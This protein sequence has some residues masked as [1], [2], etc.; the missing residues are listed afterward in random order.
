MKTIQHTLSLKCSYP[1]ERLLSSLPP[2]PT[3]TSGPIGNP[4]F[5]DIETTG[6]SGDRSMLYLIG[7]LVPG[8][9]GFRAGAADRLFHPSK[10]AGPPEG[11]SHPAPF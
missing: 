10:G 2:D 9:T 4:L 6:F 8:H 7:C 11:L 3:H 5:F 1:L